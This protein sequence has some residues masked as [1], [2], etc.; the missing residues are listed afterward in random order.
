[1]CESHPVDI[2]DLALVAQL[3]RNG[4]AGGAVLKR[5]NTVSMT[6][7]GSDGF[8]SLCAIRPGYTQGLG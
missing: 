3:E 6:R 4:L 2:S 1:M 7:S 8:R 5:F